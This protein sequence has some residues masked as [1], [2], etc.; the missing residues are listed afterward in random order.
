MPLSTLEIGLGVACGGLLIA[1]IVTIVIANKRKK[2]GFST[3]QRLHLASQY[4]RHPNLL[5]PT[6]KQQPATNTILLPLGNAG[7][8]DSPMSYLLPSN[9]VDKQVAQP[10]TANVTDAPPIIGGTETAPSVP[11][12]ANGVALNVSSEDAIK[13]GANS[14]AGTDFHD[15]SI[16]DTSALPAVVQNGVIDS[17][18]AEGFVGGNTRVYPPVLNNGSFAVAHKAQR[19]GISTSRE[20]FRPSKHGYTG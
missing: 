12:D 17:P 6:D 3:G 4:A 19:G 15:Q 1:L 16:P 7:R 18:A 11:P 13:A 8:G 14:I 2:E 9:G 10:P 5:M 20:G